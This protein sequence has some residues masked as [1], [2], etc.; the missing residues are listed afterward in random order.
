MYCKITTATKLRKSIKTNSMRNLTSALTCD[1]FIK[2]GR[3]R[4]GCSAQKLLEMIIA[5]LVAILV[6]DSDHFAEELQIRN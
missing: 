1:K 2:A 3:K 6:L 5:Q 4:G